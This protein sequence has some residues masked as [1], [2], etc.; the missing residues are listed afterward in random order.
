MTETDVRAWWNYQE[1]VELQD[2]LV[3]KSKTKANQEK[4][5]TE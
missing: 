5:I 2:S 4:I 1:K 3:W